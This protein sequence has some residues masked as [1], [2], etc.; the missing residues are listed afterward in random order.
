MKIA[1]VRWTPVFTPFHR[2]E[3]WTWS[4]RRGMTSMVIEVETD[5]GL[6]GI[7]EAAAWPSLELTEQAL[8]SIRSVVLGEDPLRV[9]RL[10]RLAQVI[11]GWRHAAPAGNPA[12]SGFESALWDIV[13]KFAGL[14]LHA[15]FGGAVRDRVEYFYYLMR[16]APEAVAQEARTA[17]DAGFRTLYIKIGVDKEADL[18][19]LAAIRDEC[20]PQEA[21]LRID[22]N[23]AWSFGTAREMLDRLE[24]LKVEFLEQ[25]TL[26]WNLPELARL[27]STRTGI[28]ANESSWQE[29]DVVDCLRHGAADVISLDQQMLGSLS[30]LR[31]AAN[32]CEAW[33]YPV[34][35][36]SF[37]ELG[38]ATAAAMH[39]IATSSNFLF[40]NQSY[41]SVVHDDIVSSPDLKCKDGFLDL[42]TGPGL[43]VEV[44]RAKLGALNE[45]FEREASEFELLSVG[46]VPAVPRY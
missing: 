23:E 11:P 22:P 12:L 7:G 18:E 4:V 16:G 10:W 38:I 28:L 40:A 34:L 46:D 39:V 15:L 6:V 31:K 24:P 14:P 37:G 35:K 9:E 45:A 32:M 5:D 27:R 29:R 42:P 3:A 19:L 8:R 30:L 41:A 44:D 1:E 26:A 2:P 21:A 17:V 33:G 36:H 20:G 13:G 43:G 25:P